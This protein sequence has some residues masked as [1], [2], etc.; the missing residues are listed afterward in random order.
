MPQKPL[1]PAHAKFVAEYLKDGNASRAAEAI[2]YSPKNPRQ[3]G[4]KLLQLPEIQ[5]AIDETRKKIQAKA[6]YNLERAMTEAEEAIE[7][8][9]QTD[10]ANAYVKAVELRSKLNGLL[11]EKV[12]VRQS[13][14]V[15]NIAAFGQPAQALPAPEGP[16]AID[17]TP[18]REPESDDDAIW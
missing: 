8:A 9:R 5:A 4:Y 1:N 16:P 10:N 12:D 6:G 3:G 2:G 17:V 7:F 11:V 18:T 13:G 14:F 15:L